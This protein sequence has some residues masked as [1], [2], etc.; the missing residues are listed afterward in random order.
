MDPFSSLLTGHIAGKMMD[1][2]QSKF[3]TH[4]IE[5]WTKRR[6]EGFFEEFCR[7]VEFELAGKKSDKLDELLNKILEDETCS[8]VLFDAYRRVSF[9]K[10]KNLGPRIIGI[11]S[12]QLVLEKRTASEEEDNM[13]LAAENL[14]DDE[15]LEFSRFVREQSMRAEDESKKDVYY[16]PKGDLQIEWGKEQ[17]DSN[18]N[19]NT[20][21]SLA[22]LDLN[23]CL[24]RWAA[25]LKT[26]NIIS[27]DVKENQWDYQE[28]SERHIDEPG[29][30]REVSWWLYIPNPYLRFADLIER[31]AGFS[32]NI[33][34][35]KPETT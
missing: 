33:N 28:D 18:W 17:F 1:Y 35:H 15:L 23:E 4:V 12:A 31:V 10:S 26:F 13:L 22:P 16:N 25:K 8:E 29:T 30:V 6:A 19:R 27:D 5:R 2:I 11:L 14:M 9:T 7:E 24:G 32:Q 34:N 20:D 21:V 3:R